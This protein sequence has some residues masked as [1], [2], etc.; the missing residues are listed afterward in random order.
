MIERK[1][2]TREMPS[3]I[4][5]YSEE[6]MEDYNSK[7][8]HS[9]TIHVECC[10]SHLICK[11]AMSLSRRSHLERLDPIDTVV[12][13]ITSSFYSFRWFRYH[14]EL[15]ERHYRII[16]KLTNFSLGLL[17]RFA[18]GVVGSDGASIGERK[19]SDLIR[20]GFFHD[21]TSSVSPI[22]LN[23]PHVHISDCEW[24]SWRHIRCVMLHP[25]RRSGVRGS[26]REEKNDWL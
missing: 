8:H 25:W 26:L 12:L 24:T 13:T 3:M 22:I 21:T 1:D 17:D 19:L 9:S 10:P 15:S 14:I 7:S 23:L 20:I 11:C 6:S 18:L 2:N 5:S 4:P 16:L